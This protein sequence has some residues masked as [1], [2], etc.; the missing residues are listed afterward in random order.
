[1][2]PFASRARVADGSRMSRCPTLLPLALLAS[3]AGCAPDEPN[4]DPREAAAGE[5]RALQDAAAMLDERRA[6]PA[7][8][9][10]PDPRPETP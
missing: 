8:D 7:A 1:M 6:S 9:A 4:R 2:R 10:P 5:A 3:M